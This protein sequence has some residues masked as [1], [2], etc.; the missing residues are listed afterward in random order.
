MVAPDG[1]PLAGIG[2]LITRPAAQAAGIAA[3]I[4]DAGGKAIVFPTIEITGP[5]EPARLADIVARLDT[6]DIA[7]FI[8][9]NAVLGAASLIRDRWPV[10]PPHLKVVAVGPASARHVREQGLGEAV[11]PAD[12]ASSESL[13]GLPLLTDVA[14]KRVLIFRGQGGREL[15]ADTLRQRGAHVEYAESYRRGMPQADP[16]ALLAKWR[17]GEVH[18][19][20]LTS[21]EA[22]ENLRTLLGP[23]GD[24]LLR[25]TPCVVA[26]ERIAE[27]TRALA[28]NAVVTRSADDHAF[29][30][31]L[32][33][34]R[35]QQKSL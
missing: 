35:A 10:L 7:I 15:L 4:E 13:L 33:A 5:K 12:G 31:A 6:Y 21:T 34:W 32:K 2:V 28:M 19:V 25:Q 18:A 29:L 9:A 26:S 20:L 1:R 16:S 22:L 8:S 3:L 14:N 23:D 11:A 17:Q 24:R 30:A 27:A